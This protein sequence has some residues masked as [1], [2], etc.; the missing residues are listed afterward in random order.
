MKKVIEGEKIEISRHSTNH[1]K[2]SW[3]EGFSSSLQKK[4]M[5]RKGDSLTIGLP[6][7]LVEESFSNEAENLLF[8]FNILNH[9]CKTLLGKSVSDLVRG[10]YGMPGEIAKLL[11][12]M[13]NEGYAIRQQLEEK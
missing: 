10:T 1:F 3:P 13:S 8:K 12:L 9:E 6:P 5:L 4:I 2:F 11:D 7:Y